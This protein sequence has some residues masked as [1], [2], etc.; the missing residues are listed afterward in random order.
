MTLA[1]KF[2]DVKDPNSISGAIYL[3]AVTG[4]KK[5]YSGRV[6]E[7]PIEAGAHIT[8]HYI[9]KNPKVRISGVITGVDF[10]ITP[11]SLINPE[12]EEEPFLNYQE[13]PEAVMVQG[14]G[15]LLRQLL[16]GVISQ[17]LP[18]I[19]PQ[20][21]MDENER[22]NFKED[23]DLLIKDLIN[24][25]IFDQKRQR[26]VNRMTPITI[27]DVYDGTPTISMEDLILTKFSSEENVENGDALV[28]DMEM[29]Q[30]RF[31]TLEEAE[32]PKAQRNSSTERATTPTKDKGNA[33]TNPEPAPQDRPTVLGNLGAAGS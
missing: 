10:A 18:Q 7:H 4:Y 19:D 28:F 15:S 24:G 5:E 6:T 32:A 20:V 33:P 9:S 13:P 26:W 23:I 11:Q 21:I 30:V 2:G 29:E 8:D 14:T 12:Q 1:I 16:P 22:L 17:F 31:V 25:L 27:Y 3:D